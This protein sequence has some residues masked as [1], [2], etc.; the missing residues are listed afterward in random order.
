MILRWHK[1]GLTER[2][3]TGKA[4]E[5]G[6]AAEIQDKNTANAN[7]PGTTERSA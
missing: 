2:A 4:N 6:R 1:K 5:R 3:R 7:G